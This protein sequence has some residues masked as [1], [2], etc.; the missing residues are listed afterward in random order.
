MMKDIGKSFC[1]WG[2]P[3]LSAFQE[4]EKE[5]HGEGENSK[6]IFLSILHKEI[7]EWG[8]IGS[9]TRS[10]YTEYQ[11]KLLDIYEWEELEGGDH[12]FCKVLVF[13]VTSDATTHWPSLTLTAT[14]QIQLWNNSI[15]LCTHDWF[16]V[17]LYT[18]CLL[19]GSD[20]KFTW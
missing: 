5:K 6:S 8:I 15:Q 2:K 3:T 19:N 12:I 14:Y 1:S 11:Q 13:S 17:N 7:S 4:A 10:Y 16:K 18:Y 9:L 20:R